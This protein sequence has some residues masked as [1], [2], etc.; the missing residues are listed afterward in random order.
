[1]TPPGLAYRPDLVSEA[2]EAELI[3]W[4]G[5]VEFLEIACA[6]RSRAGPSATMD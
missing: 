6:V 5:D 1:V 4:L 3:A 2:E